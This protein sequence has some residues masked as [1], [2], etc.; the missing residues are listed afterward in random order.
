M[1]LD[2]FPKSKEALLECYL[3]LLE[4][5]A[6]KLLGYEKYKDGEKSNVFFSLMYQVLVF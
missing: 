5:Q 2:N 4:S 1:I 6:C 3:W